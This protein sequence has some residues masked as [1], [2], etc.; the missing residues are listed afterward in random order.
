MF[1]NSK[2]SSRIDNF[3][4]RPEVS[5]Y[6]KID[7]I[8]FQLQR[9]V[10]CKLQHLASMYNRKIPRILGRRRTRKSFQPR[11]LAEDCEL[12]DI[13]EKKHNAFQLIRYYGIRLLASLLYSHSSEE[14]SR[15]IR[16]RWKTTKSSLGRVHLGSGVSGPPALE[17]Q[18]YIFGNT[19]LCT[20]WQQPESPPPLFLYFSDSAL[21][22]FPRFLSPFFFQGFGN[23]LRI[24]LD[25]PRIELLCCMSCRL[26]S[27][28][29]DFVLFSA[30]N[31]SLLPNR[32]ISALMPV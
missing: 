2:E 1:N 10:N 32:G 4:R 17:C 18:A 29:L 25:A 11:I 8:R 22:S 21:T 28:P 27:V 6:I 5:L 23:N 3:F 31:A 9:C 13:I 19:Q 20:A 7:R 24:S 14:C 30:V 15:R 26:I 16:T 12:P